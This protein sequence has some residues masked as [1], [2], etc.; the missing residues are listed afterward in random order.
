MKN[1]PLIVGIGGTTVRSS[2][3]LLNQFVKQMD[4]LLDHLPIMVV[5]RVW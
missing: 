4:W 3:N 5:T 2:N 1:K